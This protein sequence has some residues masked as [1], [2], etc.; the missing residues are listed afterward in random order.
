MTHAQV[1]F[2]SL[3]SGIK[4]QR[5]PFGSRVHNDREQLLCAHVS[6]KSACLMRRSD[7]LVIYASE[8]S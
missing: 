5:L 2:V 8:A 4:A 7:K 1:F 6:A 3:Y